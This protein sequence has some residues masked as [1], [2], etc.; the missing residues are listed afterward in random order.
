[1]TSR[2]SWLLACGWLLLVPGVAACPDRVFASP[3][4]DAPT[5]RKG[6]LDP[7]ERPDSVALLS[8]PP[9]PG[10]TA[11][12]RDQ[13]VRDEMRRYRD[14]P[15]WKMAAADA[16]LAFPRAVGHFDCALG[17]SIGRE[18]TPALYELMQRT[19]IDAGQSTLAAKDRY[20]RPRPFTLDA[21]PTCL[22]DSEDAL[23]RSP[24]YPSGH[25]S[26]GWTWALLLAE[27]APERA[28][29]LRARGAAFGQSRVVCDV[30]WQSDVDAGRVVA[31]AVVA[32][33]R[34]EPEFQ[35][36]LAQARAEVA[37]LRRGQA[38]SVDVPDVARCEMEKTVLADAPAA[39]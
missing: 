28:D 10:S 26:L 18:R 29:A 13:R 17:F 15:R 36:V 8:P 37:S 2:G 22:P 31:E 35:R 27:L 7:G 32:R 16:D 39:P 6:F 38:A 1:V 5:E 4:T 24:G 9:Q 3:V 12:D 20:K 34:D 11:M 19:V 33:L 14:T 21:S 23:R 30:H 25:A